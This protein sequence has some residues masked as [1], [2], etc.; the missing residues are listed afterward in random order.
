MKRA[1]VRIYNQRGKLRKIFTPK[2]SSD[3]YYMHEMFTENR[4]FDFSE[5]LSNFLNTAGKKESKHTYS[6]FNTFVKFGS[7]HQQQED[8]TVVIRTK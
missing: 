6:L 7:V 2:K 4:S 1:K 3:L 5:Q 8:F